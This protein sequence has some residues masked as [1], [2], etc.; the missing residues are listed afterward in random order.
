M[1]RS[2]VR[3]NEVPPPGTAANRRPISNLNQVDPAQTR[4]VPARR[5]H[6]VCN[7]DRY[8]GTRCGSR[9]HTSSRTTDFR[10]VVSAN[11]A[12][13]AHA[14]PFSLRPA[15]TRGPGSA[16][17]VCGLLRLL[18]GV[19][20]PVL[21]DLPPVVG[22]E[23]PR[24]GLAEGPRIAGVGQV[25]HQLGIQCLGLVGQRRFGGDIA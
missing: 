7:T 2:L 8:S 16:T 1:G 3:A 20:G 18:W 14:G 5:H 19:H 24:R 11:F 6:F 22:I 25:R 13:A 4:Q 10:S 12:S 23:V 17:Y 9:T 21:V 15:A